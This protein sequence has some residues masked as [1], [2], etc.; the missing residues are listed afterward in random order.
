MARG[1]DLVIG[2]ARARGVRAGALGYS[3]SRP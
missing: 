2:V 1:I 3:N